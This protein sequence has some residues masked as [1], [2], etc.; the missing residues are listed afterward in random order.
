[1]R[2]ES[3]DKTRD[4]KILTGMIVDAAVLGKLAPK[5]PKEGLFRHKW[6]NLIAGWCIRYYN[7]YGKAPGK[8]IDGLFYSWAEDNQDDE[9]AELI[10]RLLTK[11]SGEYKRLAKDSNSDY[12]IDIATE[13]FN[14]II[15]EQHIEALQGHVES[16]H[17]DKAFKLASRF[18]KLEVGLQSYVDL[19][20]D[21]SVIEKAF[22]KRQESMVHYKGALGNFFEDAFDREMFVSFMGPEKRGKSWWLM[23]VGWRA[24][25][26][27]RKVAFFEVG[28]MSQGQ[29]IRRFMVRATG[30]P[31]KKPTRDKPIR[32]PTHLE[33]IEKKGVLPEV[34]FKEY[35][36]TKIVNK[37]S[38]LKICNQISKSHGEEPLLKLWSYPNSSASIQTVQSELQLLERD[39]WL[40]D[41]VIIDYADLLVPLPGY[42]ESRHQIDATWR[43]MRG[44]SQR[45][46]CCVVTATQANAASF[47]AETLDRTNFSESK[48]KYA[49]VNA[50]IAINQTLEEKRSQLMRLSWLVLRESG[51][52]E[53]K[54]VH[55]AGCLGLANPAMFSTF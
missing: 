3:F 16:G 18:G 1:M 37:K 53:E 35:K 39:G 23:D 47:Y 32:V 44:L 34:E 22:A 31:L 13:H 45:L 46:H 38:A 12:I 30:L 54:C 48:T 2:V 27:G 55:V 28:D 25:F 6:A 41:F 15:T 43:A 4:K 49:H 42:Q 19:F 10:S 52:D 33:P 14:K 7:K 9:T 26:Q 29:A 8:N 24:M 21:K 11:L 5:W 51:Y 20:Q 17:I 50:M 36:F 40:P